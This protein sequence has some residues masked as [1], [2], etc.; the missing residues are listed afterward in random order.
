MS[1]ETLEMICSACGFRWVSDPN[2]HEPEVCPRC[3]HGG[4]PDMEGYLKK[5]SP[6]S[7]K[8]FAPQTLNE[9]LNKPIPLADPVITKDGNLLLDSGGRLLVHAFS[10]RGK[11]QFTLQLALGLALGEPTLGFEFTRPRKVLYLNGE[12]SERQLRKRIQFLLNRGFSSTN[13]FLIEKIN[14]DFILQKTESFI[15][16][17][18]ILEIQ[19]LVIDPLYKLNNGDESLQDLKIITTILDSIRDETGISIV[20]VHHQAKQSMNSNS[21]PAQQQAR[22]SSHLTDWFDCVFSFYPQQRK[23]PYIQICVDGREDPVDD[24]FYRLDN[25]TRIYTPISKQEAQMLTPILTVDLKQPIITFISERGGVNKSDLNN[26]FPHDRGL[27]NSTLEELVQAGI[28]DKKREGRSEIYNVHVHASN[29]HEYCVGTMDMDDTRS[30][31]P[32]SQDGESGV[33]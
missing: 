4:I 25:D 31:D 22:G 24:L 20:T 30:P 26:R 32:A 7:D 9:F 11:T 14:P 5:L 29:P 6:A 21:R 10:K 13:D 8:F 16:K 1:P 18:R 27:L 3:G 23:L 28:L 17:L 12:L 15:D 33:L 2:K 19:I